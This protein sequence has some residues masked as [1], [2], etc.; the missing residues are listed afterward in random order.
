VHACGPEL[1]NDELHQ[2]VIQA[3][4]ANETDFFP[5]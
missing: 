5:G 1:F 2:R 4:I 3:S